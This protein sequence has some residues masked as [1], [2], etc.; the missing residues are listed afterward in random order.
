M[1]NKEDKSFAFGVVELSGFPYV[2]IYPFTVIKNK[3]NTELKV[4]YSESERDPVYTDYAEEFYNKIVDT[5]LFLDKGHDLNE[6]VHLGVDGV[7][8]IVLFNKFDDALS[9]A[10]KCMDFKL[11]KIFL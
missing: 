8:N 7:H 9:F 3:D 1:M 6:S 5:S 10:E 4:M 2:Q 11:L